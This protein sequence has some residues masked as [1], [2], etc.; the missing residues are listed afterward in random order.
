MQTLLRT[1]KGPLVRFERDTLLMQDDSRWLIPPH[2][3]AWFGMFCIWAAWFS[4]VG[5][6]WNQPARSG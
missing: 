2:Q 6:A 3:L 4:L 5:R 1:D